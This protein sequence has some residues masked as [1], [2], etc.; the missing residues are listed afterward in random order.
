[1][2][3]PAFNVSDKVRHI[4]NPEFAMVIKGFAVKWTNNLYNEANGIPNPEYPICTFYNIY[5]Q[6]WEEEMF[7]YTE[8]ELVA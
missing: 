5:T 1:M 3:D 8:L 7:L 2:A 6:K 4:A